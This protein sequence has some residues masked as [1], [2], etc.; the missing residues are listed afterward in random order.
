MPRKFKVELPP[1]FFRFALGPCIP[2]D[3]FSGWTMFCVYD[4]DEIVIGLVGVFDLDHGERY[5]EAVFQ[6]GVGESVKSA[7][8]CLGTYCGVFRRICRFIFLPPGSG[9][10]FGFPSTRSMLGYWDNLPF[11][12]GEPVLDVCGSFG[13]FR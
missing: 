8:W 5:V 13:V 3:S 10:I 4:H 11:G 1:N 6:L 9:L 7:E 2:S 12:F